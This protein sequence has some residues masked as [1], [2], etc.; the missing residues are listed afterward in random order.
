MFWS[1]TPHASVTSHP[2][3]F[4]LLMPTG[5][6]PCPAPMPLSLLRPHKQDGVLLLLAMTPHHAY[7][8]CNDCHIRRRPATPARRSLLGPS[9]LHIDLEAELWHSEPRWHHAC[10]LS[11]TQASCPWP[12][13]QV[14]WA[15]DCP[16]PATAAAHNT[17][18]EYVLGHRC[19]SPIF[20]ARLSNATMLFLRQNTSMAR[21]PWVGS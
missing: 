18:S 3:R 14:P 8:P 11:A 16:L 6:C 1:S 7:P 15:L 2:R 13:P 12:Q 10:M 17:H 4:G 20:L 5:D 19:V 9:A 21:P